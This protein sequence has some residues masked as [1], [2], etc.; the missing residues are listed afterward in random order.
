MTA[1]ALTFVPAPRTTSDEP[2]PEPVAP[3]PVSR[4]VTPIGPDDAVMLPR[5]IADAAYHVLQAM[6]ALKDNGADDL[7]AALGKALRKGSY[8]PQVEQA[9]PCA[10]CHVDVAYG[11]AHH[12]QCYS[13]DATAHRGMQIP[14]VEPEV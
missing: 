3:P 1:E 7:F 6:H 4:E 13:E 8:Q 9:P 5:H 12:P 11:L 14:Q 10:I 2:A